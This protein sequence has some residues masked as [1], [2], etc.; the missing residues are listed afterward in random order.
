MVKSKHKAWLKW[1]GFILLIPSIAI[2]IF[3]ST[4]PTNDYS[5]KVIEVLDGDTILLDG[6]VRLRLR[7][8]DAPE[9]EFCLG[10][11]SKNYLEE[12]VKGKDI[13]IKEYIIDQYNRPMALV[14]LGKELIN[15][16]MLESGLVRYHSDK[17]SATDQLKAIG[18]QVKED[19]LG[20]YSPQCYQTDTNLDDPD[21]IIKGNI[22]LNNKNI[23]RYYYPGCA[24]YKY[25]IVEKD[26]GE[27]WFCT[28][29]K[30]KKAGYVK[31]KSCP[32]K[33]PSSN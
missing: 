21:C 24:Q 18:K 1:L 10:Q 12:L 5:I 33:N 9:P 16:T 26:K 23:K 17:T 31:A 6:K 15:Q 14:Y 25:V 20:V 2:N 11:E 8:I 4:R 7:H 27:D 28:E 3:F 13:T 30:A 19:R 29:S 22:D 32:N